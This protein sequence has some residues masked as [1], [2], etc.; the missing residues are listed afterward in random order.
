MLI[1]IIHLSACMGHLP[2]VT[3]YGAYVL[4]LL[5]DNFQTIEITSDQL[6]LVCTVWSVKC[7]ITPLKIEQFVIMAWGLSREDNRQK[8]DI[9][10]TLNTMQRTGEII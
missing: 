4:Q 2:L 6:C 9:T 5:C 10:R 8:R 1:L 7:L 3:P